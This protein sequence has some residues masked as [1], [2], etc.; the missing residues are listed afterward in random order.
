MRVLIDI[1]S[2]E[3]GGAERQVVLLASGLAARGD[4][5]LVVVNKRVNSY[6]GE[7]V[8]R[9]ID[10]LELGRE[11]RFDV[12][13]L[14]NLVQ[15]VHAF[16]PDVILCIS[17][18]A[19]L[20]GRLAA[21][22]TGTPVVVA[23]H[24]LRSYRPGGF[25]VLSNRLLAPFTS[26]VVACAHG[27]KTSLIARGHRSSQIRVVH[28]GIDV[29]AFVRS[30]ELRKT[31]RADLGIPRG[32][33]LVGLVAGHRREKRH[34]RFIAVM[35]K[36]C[37]E[38]TDAWGLMV[39]DGALFERNA[40]AV[41][42]SCVA[43]RIGILGARTDVEAVYSACDAVALVSDS[44]VFPMCLLEA[45]ACAVPVV[46]MDVGGVS[47]TFRDGKTGFLVQRGDVDGMARALR[48]LAGNA[49]L[50]ARMGAEARHL[51]EREFTIDRMVAQYAEVFGS[52]A[53]IRD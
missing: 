46:A 28:N 19:S 47:E 38:G 2:I 40:R 21:M 20:W 3:D 6:R 8:A 31:I 12:R 5:P 34:D 52:A 18:N 4:A 48:T 45:Q 42:Q 50:R 13:L 41:R 32:S 7:M 37:A 27:Q 24:N 29:D 17:F 51:A 9:G 39:G 22:A 30:E 33:L 25:V 44:E 15:Q 14:S 35:E 49:E 53:G 10:V 23:E 36:L 16:R 43:A 1:A 26:A 11:S